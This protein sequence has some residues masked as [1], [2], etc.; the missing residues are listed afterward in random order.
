MFTLNSLKPESRLEVLKTR[1]GGGAEIQWLLSSGAVCVCVVGGGVKRR[2]PARC[3]Q[4]G[5]A[6]PSGLRRAQQHRSSVSRLDRRFGEDLGRLRRRCSPRGNHGC[7]GEELARQRSRETLCPGGK[8]FLSA[9]KQFGLEFK[10]QK[11]SG[12]L[13][14]EALAAEL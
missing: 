2:V 4:T 6:E 5:A 10:H 13:L 11:P 3:E 8:V 14:T 12:L 7:V 1:V 9:L